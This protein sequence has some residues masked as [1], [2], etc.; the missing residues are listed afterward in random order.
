MIVTPSGE[1]WVVGRT[2]L[3]DRDKAAHITSNAIDSRDE[4]SRK[5]EF[6]QQQV[7]FRCMVK[8]YI[9]P[10][11]MAERAPSIDRLLVQQ[12]KH[13]AQLTLDIMT[14]HNRVSHRQIDS[15]VSDEEERYKTPS[16]SCQRRNIPPSPSLSGR[17]VCCTDVPYGFHISTSAN[18]RSRR[19]Y[20]PVSK[21]NFPT[22]QRRDFH[23]C[24]WLVSL[25]SCITRRKEEAVELMPHDFS[26]T[27]YMLGCIIKKGHPDGSIVISLTSNFR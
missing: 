4:N 14:I 23:D 7:E 21:K 8:H 26:D 1:I 9:F 11:Y 24:C 5:E 27:Y 25:F 2:R 19:G 17:Y 16:N 12:V 3:L 22:L 20:T 10:S 13:L 15:N 18:E 6:L